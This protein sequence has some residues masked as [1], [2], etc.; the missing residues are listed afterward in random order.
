MHTSTFEFFSLVSSRLKPS[1]KAVLNIA[2]NPRL[3]DAYSVNM[4]FTVRQALSRC[5]TDITGYQNALVNIVYFCSK[6]SS[7]DN[8]AVA[9]LYRDDTTK[10]TVDGYVSSLNIKKW[11]S[12]E[13]NN[14]GQ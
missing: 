8:E 10:V 14:H 5:I 7:M 4:D 3:N 1:G 11:Q 6:K 9:S 13:D 12:R 2:A